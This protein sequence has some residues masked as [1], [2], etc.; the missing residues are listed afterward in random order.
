[1]KFLGR[2]SNLRL[3]CRR[4]LLFA[5][6]YWW[7]LAVLAIG[8]LL[9]AVT[10]YQFLAKYG[11]DEELRPDVRLVLRIMPVWA[12]PF[13]AKLV[14]SAFVIFVA[15]IWRGWCKWLI[16]ICGVFY[17]LAAASN[18]FNWPLILYKL[19]PSLMPV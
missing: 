10:T 14:Q 17:C 8:A 18:A 7:A 9:D 5:R 1:M 12:G 16:A 3:L 19:F 15:A 4:P 11:P 13:F 6:A 2:K